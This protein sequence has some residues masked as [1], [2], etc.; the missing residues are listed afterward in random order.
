MFLMRERG[1]GADHAPNVIHTPWDTAERRYKLITYVYYDGYWGATSLDGKQWKDLPAPIFDDPGDVG[2][3]VWD[4]NRN[5]YIGYPKVFTQERGFRRRSV[6]FTE[7]KE[8]DR[9]PKPRLILAPD[10]EDD[11]W[12]TSKEGHTDFYGLSGFPYQSMYIG[13]LWIYRIDKGDE[14][15]WPEL[16]YS[17]DGVNWIRQPAPRRPVLPLGPPGTWDDGMIY[18]SNHPL[19]REDKLFLYYGGFDGPHNSRVANGAIGLA[20]MRRDGFASMDGT[21]PSSQVTSKLLENVSGTLAVNADASAGAL[22]GEV[23]DQSGKVIPGYEKANCEPVRVNSVQAEV[24]WKGQARLP[25]GRPV[26]LRFWLENA[27]L[28]SFL[29]GPSVR[30]VP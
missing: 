26:K 17:K 16:I 5:S 11:R 6:G 7:T 4:A 13:F 30:I 27:S 9:W 23:L 3:F 15:V 1:R 29:A 25:Q 22:R 28:Y 2:N 24:K 19:I 8:F 14:R 20:M 12:V 10:V 18:T 21:G